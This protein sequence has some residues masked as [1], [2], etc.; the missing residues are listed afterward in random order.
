MSCFGPFEIHLYRTPLGEAQFLLC[1]MCLKIDLAALVQSVWHFCLNAVYTARE[2]RSLEGERVWERERERERE[3]GRKREREKE[4]EKERERE[5]ERQR[6][7]EGERKRQGD[8]ETE[9]ERERERGRESRETGWCMWRWRLITHMP[10]KLRAI[11][12]MWI[13]REQ[14]FEMCVAMGDASGILTAMRHKIRLTRWS[15]AWSIAEKL[16]PVF[17]VCL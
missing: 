6:K 9:R 10:R 12:H 3:R 7:T 13:P 2:L 1:S 14:E 11:V 16:N 8:R 5:R 4:V 17:P 15:G